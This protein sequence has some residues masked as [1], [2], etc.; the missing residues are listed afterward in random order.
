MMYGGDVSGEAYQTVLRSSDFPDAPTWSF[1]SENPPVSVKEAVKLATEA[2]TNVLGNHDGWSLQDITLMKSPGD[3]WIYKVD[4]L[5]PI[6][7]PHSPSTF[8]FGKQAQSKSSLVVFVLMD[9]HVVFP[10]PI[11]STALEPMPT[12]P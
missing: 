5:G 7:K 1:H 12:M 3:Y 11:T 8:G 10:K 2:L 4:F 9:G 6:Y